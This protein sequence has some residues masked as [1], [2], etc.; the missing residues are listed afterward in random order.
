MPIGVQVVYVFDG[1]IGLDLPNH[2]A[3]I[4]LFE[5]TTSATCCVMDGTY[6]TGIR[7]AAPSARMLSRRD[8]RVATVIGAGV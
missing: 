1:N 5:A 6:L 8:A 7:T 4:V 2:L 3:M